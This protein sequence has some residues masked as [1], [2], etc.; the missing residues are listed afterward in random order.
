MTSPARLRLSRARGF[1]LQAV[2]LALNGLPAINCARPGPYGNPWRVSIDA[3][4][5]DTFLCG[6]AGEAVR[7]HRDFLDML[8]SLDVGRRYLRP[9]VGHNLACW[10]A[11]SS[12]CHVGNYLELIAELKLARIQ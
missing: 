1:D 10:C 4:P 8:S 5:E 11:P 6:S 12:P 2:S 7:I 3:R 9:L